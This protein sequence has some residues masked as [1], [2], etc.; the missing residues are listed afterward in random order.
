MGTN[1]QIMFCLPEFEVKLETKN[2]A[3]FMFKAYKTLHYTMKNQGRI[4]TV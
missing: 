1:N 2:E 3:I 4:N